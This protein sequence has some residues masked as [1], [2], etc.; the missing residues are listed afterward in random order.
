MA[1]DPGQVQQAGVEPVEKREVA[2]CAAKALPAVAANGG[3]FESIV[4]WHGL[5]PW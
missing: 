5:D 2:A 1:V 3:T 4:D